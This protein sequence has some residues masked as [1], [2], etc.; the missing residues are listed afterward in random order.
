[1]IEINL[2]PEELRIKTKGRSPDAAKETV[3]AA[4][5]QE[6][7]LIYIIPVV[8]GLLI[9]AHLYFTV[10]LVTKNSELIS[11][12]RKWSSLAPQKKALEEFNREFSG[13]QQYAG[14]LQLQ[15]S[16]RVLW[17][18]KLNELSLQLPSGIWF[19]EIVLDNANLTVRGSVISLEKNE[20]GL[21]NKLLG[22]LK[23]TSAFAKD[24]TNF[25]LSN[26][27]RRTVGGYE[28]ADFVIVG[29]LK[30]K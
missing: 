14:F 13:N 30:T 28:I 4:L 20:V 26:V 23:S 2:L 27:Q 16:Q 17:S 7:L 6:R 3:P 19:N 21:L 5:L 9:L 8:L 25:E 29:A 24:F 18:P 10:L 12:N 22:N 11:L 1:M 15:A